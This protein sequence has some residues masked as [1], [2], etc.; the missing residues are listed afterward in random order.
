MQ[1]LGLAGIM[2]NPKTS[3][4]FFIGAI[5]EYPGFASAWTAVAGLWKT[6]TSNGCGEVSSMKIST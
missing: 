2:A 3:D 4:A 6:C 5:Q 1:K